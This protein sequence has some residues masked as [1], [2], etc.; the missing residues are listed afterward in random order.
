MLEIAAVTDDQLDV[1]LDVCGICQLLWFDPGE[2]D[3][4]PKSNSTV[5][6]GPRIDE[7]HCGHCGAPSRPDLDSYCKYCHQ[8]MAPARTPGVTQSSIVPLPPVEDE[9]PPSAADWIGGLLRL[10][11]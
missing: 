3:R 1:Q 10:L 11:G 2:L 8:P 9:R 6:A 7:I 5:F 4:L